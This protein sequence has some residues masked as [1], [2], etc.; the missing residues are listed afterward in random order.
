M[1]SYAQTQAVSDDDIASDAIRDAEAA[2][3]ALALA[4]SFLERITEDIGRARQAL[5]A[6][7]ASPGH[8]RQQLRDVFEV[9]H[10]ITG[11]G[12]SFGY[13]LLTKIGGSLCNYLRDEAASADDKQLRVIAAPLY[14]ITQR[15]PRPEPGGTACRLQT[16]GRLMRQ[17]DFDPAIAR[18]P[19]AVDGRHGRFL[20]TIGLGGDLDFRQAEA[21]QCPDDFACSGPAEGHVVTA[22][23]RPV[24]V[25][26][27]PDHRRATS[28]CSIRR[29][30]DFGD[31]SRGQGRGVEI[32]IDH[33]LRR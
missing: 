17:L 25:T 30:D 12:G 24:G 32:E 10:N 4:E 18:L 27:D 22:R 14:R 26:G 16:A 3:A 33:E 23:S 31:R 13:D 20:L 7:Q 2:V 19:D 15:V 29:P 8:N 21:P 5:E 11:Q 1:D 6:A 28:P 9:V